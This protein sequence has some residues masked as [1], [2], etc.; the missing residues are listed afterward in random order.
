[1]FRKFYIFLPDPPAGFPSSGD[2]EITSNCFQKEFLT[3]LGNTSFSASPGIGSLIN[4][5]HP[6]FGMEVFLEN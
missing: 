4:S 3:Y 1:L 6:L 5:K 2:K